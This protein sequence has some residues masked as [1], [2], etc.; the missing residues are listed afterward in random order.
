M[1]KNI[2]KILQ[3]FDGYV[4]WQKINL[5]NYAKNSRKMKE[6]D[7]NNDKKLDES[8][9]DKQDQKKGWFIGIKIRLHS[10]MGNK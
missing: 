3:L 7:S 1:L 2:F 6:N 5:I 10:Y 9:V 8:I 4:Y